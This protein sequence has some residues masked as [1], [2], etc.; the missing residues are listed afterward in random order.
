LK[1]Q[2]SLTSAESKRL[3]AK[4]VVEMPE[5]RRAYEGGTIVIHPSTTTTFIF[6]ELFKEKP[7][8]VVVSGVIVPK[9]TCISMQSLQHLRE[10]N[11]FKKG[12]ETF[13]LWVIV[14][15]QL[16]PGLKLGDVLGRM[17]PGDVYVKTGNALD[18]DG[19]VGVLVGAPLGGSI[20][21][22]SRKQRERGFKLI[23]PVGL[24]KLI[25]VSVARAAE[26]AP[27]LT[28]ETGKK[29]Y[30]YSMGMPCGLL[31]LE[32]IVVTE[33]EA[34]NILTGAEATPI[35]AGGV[36]GAE[37]GLTLVVTGDGSQVGKA[38]KIIQELKGTKIPEITPSDCF[39]C[40]WPTC[41]HKGVKRD[42][43]PFS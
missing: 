8:G 19:H 22:A 7:K 38:L 43:S 17:G 23:I 6:E 24:E 31:P 20:G 34:I 4:A 15:G 12:P 25:P 35:G 16:Q 5:F 14:N 18:P 33:P 27:V 37:G 2:V 21:F 11:Y 42:P 10:N 1:A 36:A 13:R 30:D 28:K 29:A 40:I 39:T 3:I 32:G 41:P 9:G 26:V